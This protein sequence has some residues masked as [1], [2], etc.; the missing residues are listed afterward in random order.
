MRELCVSSF[1]NAELVKAAD[2]VTECPLSHLVRSLYPQ[3]KRAFFSISRF[4]GSFF[5]SSKQSS[6]LLVA[7]RDRDT[8]LSMDAELLRANPEIKLLWMLRDPRDVLTS[9]H[10][11]RPGEF[12]VKPE[13]LIKSL[14]LYHHFKNL[15]QVLTV[16]YEELVFN[17]NA[18][19]AR[20]A[21][22][23]QLEPIRNF[24]EGYK[25]FTRD[26]NVRAM[27]SVRPIDAKSVQKWK[28]NPGYLE[29]LQKVVAEHPALIPLAR[30]CGYEVNLA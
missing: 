17:A 4:V 15:A 2:D 9:T 16:R 5:S 27:H 21:Q 14:E 30:D 28:A 23:F 7:G 19:Q 6:P 25:H 12:Y 18:V 10:P 22:A 20:I 3:G 11:R 1:R 8:S 24:T 13:R 29:Y 26:E